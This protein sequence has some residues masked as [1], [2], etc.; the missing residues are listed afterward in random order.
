MQRRDIRNAFKNTLQPVLDYNKMIVTISRPKNLRDTLTK[1]Q[2]LAPDNL[3]VQQLID[4]HTIF[5]HN[6]HLQ[7]ESQPS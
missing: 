3:T 7:P 4:D 1:T 5:G 6:K 2:L